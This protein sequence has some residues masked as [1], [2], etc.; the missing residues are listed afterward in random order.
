MPKQ[1]EL[2]DERFRHLKEYVATLELHNFSKELQN[3]ITALF[4]TMAKVQS[5]RDRVDRLAISVKDEVA[6]YTGMNTTILQI[7]SMT[8]KIAK[9][10]ELIKALDTYVN[11]LKSKERAGIERAVLSNTFAANR[12]ADGMFA[13]WITLMAE[14]QAY[15][16]ASMAM[17]TDDVRQ[18][19]K[20]TMNDPAVAKVNEMRAIAKTKASSGDFG[21]DSVV[22]FQTITKKINLLK[23]ID[24][25]IS[26]LNTHLL[27]N[28]AKESR[29]RTLLIIISFLVA[30]TFI[31]GAVLMISRAVSASVARSLN[32]IECV[33]SSLDLTCDIV[34]EGKDEISQISRALHTMISAFKSTVHQAKDVAT[35]SVAESDKLLGVVD[36]LSENIEKSNDKVSD[37]NH[38]VDDVGSRLDHVEEATVTVSEDLESISSVLDAFVQKL[39]QSVQDIDASTQRQQ[40]LVEKVAS[41]QEQAKNIKDVLGII[42][43]IADQTNLLALNAAIEAARA[44]EHGRGFAVVA[45]EVRKLAE[46]T[47]SSLGEIGANISLITQNVTDIAEETSHTSEN[48]HVI[49][50]ASQEL[51]DVS[52]QTKDNLAQ[53]KEKSIEVVNESTYIATKTKELIGNM[54]EMIRL[55]QTNESLRKEVEGAAHTLSSDAAKLSDE[56]NKFK[57]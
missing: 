31:M 14:Q 30:T 3:K 43:D 40:D 55:S 29:N 42:S 15:L 34:V 54:D 57:I 24:D 28:I 45:D 10:P 7:A 5:I 32:R 50:E 37:V 33:S 4:T 2:T 49:S 35:A 27:E 19:Y 39:G 48:M 21:V 47:Q 9:T 46:R 44:G 26:V 51:I 56:L 18:F 20:Q 22:W 6:Y 13:K 41:L 16:D 23:K 11:F 38:L 52:M 36:R 25:K 8:A 53:T 12:F 17:A 1:R